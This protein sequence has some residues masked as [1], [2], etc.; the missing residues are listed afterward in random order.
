M[1]PPATA[2]VEPPKQDPAERREQQRMRLDFLNALHV[3]FKGARFFPPQNESVVKRIHDLHQIIQAVAESEGNCNI[4]HVHGFL[5]MN[6]SRVKTDAASLVAYNFIMETMARLKVGIITFAA[7]A[8]F[9]QIRSFLYVVAKMDAKDIDEDPF[10]RVEE[11]LQPLALTGITLGAQDESTLDDRNEDLRRSSVDIYFRSISVAKS[12]LQN[13][14]AGKAVNFRR[15]KR[16]VQTMVDVATEDEF[17]LLALSSIKNYDE[18]T[19]NHSANVSVLSITF[20]QH[21]GMSKKLLGSLGMAA[22]LHDVGKTDVP[23][24]VLNKAGKLTAEE[25]AEMRRH[26]MLGVKRLLRSGDASEMLMRA[27]VVAFQH[28]KR[29]DLHGYPETKEAR[30]I[31]WCSKI[32]SIVDCYD[33]LTTPR[34]YRKRSYSAAEALGIMLDDAGTAFDRL[35]LYKFALFITLYPVGTI[36]RL[37]TGE[38]ALVY[39]VRNEVEFLDRPMAKLLTDVSGGR[40]EPVVIDLAEKHDTGAFKRTVVAIIAPSAYFDNLDDY[41]KLL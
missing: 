31:D 21:L 32:V 19:Y 39:R 40:I 24:E 34:I 38:S 12:I 4:E 1:T 30:E 20:G 22:L 37:D 15:A 13:A 33:A 6:A 8:T 3:A 9:E 25:F 17:F 41:F 7:S 36:V 14:H 11:K 18:Y 23:K 26:P 2:V 28:H 27:I 29:V 35:L 16:A 5:M 10:C